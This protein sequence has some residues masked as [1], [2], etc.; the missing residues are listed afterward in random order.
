MRRLHINRSRKCFNPECR[1]IYS[2]INPHSKCCCEICRN[3]LNYLYRKAVKNGILKE[4]LEL[5]QIYAILHCYF[6]R[7]KY[8]VSEQELGE[9]G[10]DFSELL[11]VG[12][13]GPGGKVNKFILGNIELRV[14]ET[15]KF[16]IVI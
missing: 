4:N 14:T 10:V 6:D 3:R 7:R 9:A 15:K 5:K 11:K 8:E 1:S 16:K 13:I 2:P 12:K